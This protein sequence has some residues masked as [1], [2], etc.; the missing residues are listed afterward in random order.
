MTKN[1]AIPPSS[2]SRS[3]VRSGGTALVSQANAAY[4]HQIAISIRTT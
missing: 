2:G 4:I 1:A 3:A